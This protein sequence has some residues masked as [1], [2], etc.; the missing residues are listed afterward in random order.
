L[1]SGERRLRLR[2]AKLDAV[3]GSYAFRFTWLTDLPAGAL[4]ATHRGADKNATRLKLSRPWRRDATRSYVPARPPVSVSVPRGRGVVVYSPP[5]PPPPPP[6]LLNASLTKAVTLPATAISPRS[7]FTFTGTKEK[8]KKSV[9]CV[10]ALL[11]PAPTTATKRPRPVPR[12]R[13]LR[14]FASSTHRKLSA[15]P[16]SAV[17]LLSHALRPVV[18]GEPAVRSVSHPPFC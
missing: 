3:S 10:I 1:C 12:R 13:P 2:Y 8:E 11:D 14:I 16:S 7:V 4:A 5:P 18:A 9:V 17:P 15:L 6:L